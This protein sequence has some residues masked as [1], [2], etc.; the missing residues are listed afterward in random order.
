MVS[1]TCFFSPSVG[2][3]VMLWIPDSPAVS[4]FQLSVLPAPSEV[5]TPIPVTTTTGLPALSFVAVI[6]ASPS[7]HRLD[8]GEAFAAP[9]PDTRHHN[10]VQTAGHRS[11]HARLASWSEQLT[12]ADC[13][14]GE[15]DIHGKLRLQPMAEIC[16]RR[17][18]G[19]VRVLGQEAA[20]F[21]G[22]GL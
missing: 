22:G 11:F 18:D 15:R 16:T 7:G 20:L 9:M 6:S 17:A 4:F 19:N 14:R 2:K 12:M 8:K 13:D 10:L 3:R 5:T 21:C 1:S